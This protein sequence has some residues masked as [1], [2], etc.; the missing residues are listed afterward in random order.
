MEKE[1]KESRKRK[2]E[3]KEAQNNNRTKQKNTSLICRPR[4]WT[5]SATSTVPTASLNPG[6]E[7]FR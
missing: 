2:I 1:R 4:S 3:K 6:F 5:C 7:N